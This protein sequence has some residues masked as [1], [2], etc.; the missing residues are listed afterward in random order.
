MLKSIKTKA[1]RLSIPTEQ[2][3]QAALIQWCD[4]YTDRRASLIYSHLNGMRASI[5]AVVKAKAAGA[6]KGIPDLFLPVPCGEFHGLY[7]EMKRVKLGTLSSEQ[8]AW[9]DALSELG[10]RAEV[11]K[12][13]QSA[14]EVIKQ[15]LES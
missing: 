6:R 7:I 4:A 10:Y 8:K 5:G 13:H 15:Y 14:I 12:G 3:E 1:A 11:C 9:I 2:E